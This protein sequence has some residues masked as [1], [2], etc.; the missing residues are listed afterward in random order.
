MSYS[1]APQPKRCRA[2]GGGWPSPAR[3]FALVAIAVVALAHVAVAQAHDLRPGVRSA[4]PTAR[5][6]SAALEQTAGLSP[7]QVTAE[8]VCSAAPPGFA[9]CAAQA[10]VLRSNHALVRPHAR[11][12]ATFGRV[13]PAMFAPGFAQPA[14]APAAAAPNPGTPG[15]LQQ[16]YDLSYLSQTRGVGD[17]IAIVDPFDDPT[18]ESDLAVYRSQY[19]LPPC[20]TANQC[21][22]KV[23]QSGN[24]S[25][26]PARSSTWEQEIS[27]DLDAVS[28]LC[29]NCHI[30]LVEASSADS[31][32]L[33]KAMSTAASKGANQISA[34]WSIPI[35][36]GTLSGVYVFPHVSTIAATGDTGYLSN[37]TDNFPAAFSKVTAAGGTTLAPTGGARGFSEG[38][39]A[40][41]SR[42]QGAS[43]GCASQ[44]TKP[45][46][47]TDTGCTK[48]AYADLSADADPAT[49]LVFYDS[50][51]P[52]NHWGVLGGTSLAAPLIAAYYAITGG[53]WDYSTVGLHRQR[54][55]QRPGERL[56][57][58]PAP[59][60]SATSARPVGATTA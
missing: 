50:Q 6:L 19:G 10:L 51:N 11:R 54:A 12:Q 58:A 48:R 39:W 5:A 36:N 52:G 1:L 14:S 44:V 53:R 18:A 56:A 17:T 49:G 15:Y 40:F 46:Y 45:S 27:L 16:A 24:A 38:A 55:A 13:K 43:S 57:T 22:T 2:R 47:Q 9:R 41:N 37:N 21:F 34:S 35:S 31:A 25:P 60:R 4:A 20:T 23:N 29:A 32:D 26:L 8:D 7:S 28:A 3:V 33:A 30:L 59:P 42:G